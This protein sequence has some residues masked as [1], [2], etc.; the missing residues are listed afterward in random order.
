MDEKGQTFHLETFQI[1]SVDIL[2]PQ[3]GSTATNVLCALQSPPSRQDGKEQRATV[4]QC[5]S[6]AACGKLTISIGKSCQP[7]HPSQTQEGTSPLWSSSQTCNHKKNIRQS[8]IEE[9]STIQLG[10]T[11]RKC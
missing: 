2:C 5:S 11:P 9:H 8:Q 10:N 6:L 4:P 3:G 7:H 1:I